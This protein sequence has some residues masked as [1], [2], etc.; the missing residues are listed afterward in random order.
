MQ[1]YVKLT[2]SLIVCDD[3]IMVRVQ[4]QRQVSQ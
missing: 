4:H 3:N 2:V 1:M